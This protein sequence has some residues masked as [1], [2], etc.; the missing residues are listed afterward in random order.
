MRHFLLL[1]IIGINCTFVIH[2]QQIV[3][4]TTNAH[5][6][7]DYEQAQPFYLAYQEQFGSIEADIHLING[8]ILVAHDTKEVSIE[9]SLEKL[10]L[11]PLADF[12]KKNNGSPYPD[13]SKTLQLLID[14]KTEGASIKKISIHHQQ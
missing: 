12:V 9:R 11:N 10:Y 6:H 8:K 3:Y 1:L 5:S 2:A 14:Q 4:S 13:S 7:N